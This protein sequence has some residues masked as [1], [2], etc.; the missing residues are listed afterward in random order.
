MVFICPLVVLQLW[1]FRCC[2]KH[3]F[4]CDSPSLRNEIIYHRSYRLVIIPCCVHKKLDFGN[5]QTTSKL[6][7]KVYVLS[8]FF[9]ASLTARTR[10]PSFDAVGKKWYR[11]NVHLESSIWCLK[12]S[13][14]PKPNGFADHYPV[15]KRLFVWEYTLFSD[16]PIFSRQIQLRRSYPVHVT[17]DGSVR[18]WVMAA[19]MPCAAMPLIVSMLGFWH[20]LCVAKWGL[21][22]NCHVDTTYR[23][24]LSICY[25]WCWLDNDIWIMIFMILPC[26]DKKSEKKNG[27]WMNPLSGEDIGPEENGLHVERQPI[28]LVEKEGMW[29]IWVNFWLQWMIYGHDAK[30]WIHIKV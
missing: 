17:A 4:R 1:R 29:W 5:P 28:W 30:V 15:F 13:C 26:W 10:C 19:A 12:M 20:I 2:S 16:T 7:S 18:S 6:T 24:I 27:W 8:C 11:R 25:L 9:T 3:E 14:T 23:N 21:P 22:Q